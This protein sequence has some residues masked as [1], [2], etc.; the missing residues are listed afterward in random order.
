MARKTMFRSSIGG[1]AKS[2]NYTV[3]MNLGDLTVTERTTPPTPTPGSDPTPTPAPT[4][5][6]PTNPATVL[7]ANRIDPEIPTVDGG[8]VLGASRAQTGDESN[9][10]LWILLMLAS[11]AGMGIVY[12]KARKEKESKG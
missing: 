11:A 1:K 5:T 10:L 2:K 7:G 8:H 4:V 9:L 12:R 3:T 6:P